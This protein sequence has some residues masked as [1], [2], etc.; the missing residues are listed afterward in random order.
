MPS[1]VVVDVHTRNARNMH[2]DRVHVVERD[3]PVARLYQEAGLPGQGRNKPHHLN[4][5]PPLLHRVLGKRGNRFTPPVES[6][7]GQGPGYHCSKRR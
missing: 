4:V 6:E 1:C 3:V 5:P 7:I 2:L